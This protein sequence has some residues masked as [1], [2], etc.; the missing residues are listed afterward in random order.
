MKE[1]KGATCLFRVKDELVEGSIVDVVGDYI[2]MD[3]NGAKVWYEGKD[4]QVL[5]ILF[6]N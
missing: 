3:V 4:V 5:K 2:K 1:L 6:R